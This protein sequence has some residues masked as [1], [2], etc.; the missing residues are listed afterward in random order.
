MRN[1]DRSLHI[2]FWSPR[3]FKRIL[4]GVFPNLF[5]EGVEGSSVDEEHV[6]PHP[7]TA[8]NATI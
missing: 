1:E 6:L 7:Y 8:S 5:V 3:P 2:W 4:Q